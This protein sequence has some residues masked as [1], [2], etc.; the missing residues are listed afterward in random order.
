MYQYYNIQELCAVF[1]I[2][3]VNQFFKKGA[4]PKRASL[5][6]YLAVDLI[7]L[8]LCDRNVGLNT[9]CALV[10][11]SEHVEEHEPPSQALVKIINTKK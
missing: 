10:K 2:C 9:K 5:L 4:L 3:I 7:S 6:W 11:V 1:N 8:G